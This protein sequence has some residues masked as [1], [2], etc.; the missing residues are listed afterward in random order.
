ML[1]LLD[2]VHHQPLPCIIIYHDSSSLIHHSMPP[3][4]PLVRVAGGFA[5]AFVEGELVRALREGWWL[6]LDEVNLAPPEV[7][8]RLAGLLEAPPPASSSTAADGAGAS[9]GGVRVGGG[10]R[11][12]MG[13]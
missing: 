3:H 8:E 10:V 5:F 6:L 11:S 12:G 13:E 4:V 9:G 1:P 7:L 2:S